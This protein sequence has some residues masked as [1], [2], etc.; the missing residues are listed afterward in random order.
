VL[1]NTVTVEPNPTLSNLKVTRTHY[2]L[3]LAL[4]EV[5]GAEA[6]GLISWSTTEA[7]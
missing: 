1:S 4:C 3:S 2:L 7:D 5:L 6:G